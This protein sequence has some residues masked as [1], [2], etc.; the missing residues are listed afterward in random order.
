M[1]NCRPLATSAPGAEIDLCILDSNILEDCSLVLLLA[2]KPL[3]DIPE[4]DCFLETMH[5]SLL[6]SY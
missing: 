2:I 6:H 1:A 4:S 5:F 3:P